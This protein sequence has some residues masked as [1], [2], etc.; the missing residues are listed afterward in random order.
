MKNTYTVTLKVANR[1]ALADI[2]DAV[3]DKA[4]SVEIASQ[5]SAPKGPSETVTSAVTRRRKTSTQPIRRRGSK[6]NTTILEA[7]NGGQASVAD[8][9]SALEKA[10]MSPASLSTGIAAL[11]KSGEIER[12]GDGVYGRKAA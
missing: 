9:K 2:I 1:E 10:G 5:G 6:V 12:V 4:Q 7:M 3:G 8:L 11:T